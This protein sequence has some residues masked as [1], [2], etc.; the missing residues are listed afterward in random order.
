M[1]S[2]QRNVIQFLLIGFCAAKWAQAQIDPD[3]SFYQFHPSSIMSLGLGFSQND[4]ARAKRGCIQF[5]PS[6]LEPGALL[7]TFTSTLVTNSEQLKSALNVDSKVDAS[8]LLFKGSASFNLQENSAVTSDSVTVV[9]SAYTEYGRLRMKNDK[10]TSDAAA[11]VSDPVQ[12][13]KVC[14][15]RVVLV[16]HRG[17][18]VSAIITIIG[19]TSDSKS[20]ISSKLS[21]SGGW[22]PLSADA[23]V[24]VQTEMAAASS[25]NRIAVQVMATGGNGFGSLGDLVKSLLGGPDALHSIQTALGNY[26]QQFN[27]DNSAPIG[28]DV[29]S[30][31]AYGWKPTDA[32]WTQIKERKLRALVSFARDTV[33][34]QA[35]AQAILNGSDAR[36][37]EFPTAASLKDL[38]DAIPTWSTYLDALQMT[39]AACKL[40]TS[41]QGTACDPPPMALPK[42]DIIPPLPDPPVYYLDA[43]NE[44]TKQVPGGNPFLVQQSWNVNTTGRYGFD[45][46]YA[47]FIKYGACSPTTLISDLDQS[48]ARTPTASEL[49]LLQGNASQKVQIVPSSFTRTETASA[50]RIA[51][52]KATCAIFI[53]TKDKFGRLFQTPVYHSK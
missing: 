11:I 25:Q 50:I 21:A 38:Q 26:M 14:G 30:M 2:R 52:D 47:D 53:E 13:E 7:T 37:L 43:S 35:V 18:S 27:K 8:Y 19:V 3:P 33:T 51:V 41:D 12:F 29:G 24:A 1:L 46:R 39:H 5:D 34:K 32:F 17:A 31:E 16:E 48:K 49:S 44:N 10:L 28:F 20:A 40:D 36:R 6:P 45:L 15:S 4:V 42:P 9:V 22:G 23:S